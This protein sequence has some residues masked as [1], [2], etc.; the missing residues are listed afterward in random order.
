MS[1]FDKL[2]QRIKNLDKNLRFEEV[3][4]VLEAYGYVM[5]APNSGSSHY[6]FRK[7][8]CT[9]ITVPK[10]KPIK[11]IYVQMIKSIVEGDE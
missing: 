6:T 5:T 11:I 8:G 7:K 1:K 4:K 9:P 10:H 2:L 3:K